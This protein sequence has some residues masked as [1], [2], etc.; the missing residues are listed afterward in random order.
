MKIG[1]GKF[2]SK[3][4]ILYVPKAVVTALDLEDGDRV[5]YHV[6][7]GVLQIRKAK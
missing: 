1:D 6:E 3:P 4:Q 5:E 7:N 2:R